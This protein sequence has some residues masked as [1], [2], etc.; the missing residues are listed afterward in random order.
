MRGK[1]PQKII[2]EGTK[3][4]HKSGSGKKLQETKTC[5][6]ATTGVFVPAGRELAV[7][8]LRG[9]PDKMVRLLV[10]SARFFFG[11]YGSLPNAGDW[12][13]L[14]LG[15]GAFELAIPT[16]HLKQLGLVPVLAVGQY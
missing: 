16:Q 10:R 5:H 4:D 1:T 9:V 12:W 15:V 3:Q 8:L 14:W 2:F 13:C 6:P 7:K 11:A